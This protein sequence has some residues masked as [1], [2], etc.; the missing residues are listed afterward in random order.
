MVNCSVGD[1]EPGNLGVAVNL[2]KIKSCRSGINSVA[3]V[4]LTTYLQYRRVEGFVLNHVSCQI[5]VV[6]FDCQVE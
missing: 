3:V 2:G 6:V 4:A 1:Q 5:E